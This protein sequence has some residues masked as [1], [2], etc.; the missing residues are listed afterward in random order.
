MNLV[1]A[2]VT[3]DASGRG[4]RI[5]ALLLV[6]PADRSRRLQPGTEVIFGIRP[7]KISDTPRAGAHRH[8]F[9]IV[10][11]ESLGAETIFAGRMPGIDKPLFTRVGPDIRVVARRAPPLHL[12]LSAAHI[13]DADGNALRP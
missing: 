11:V 10:Q 9:E 12:D 5:G 7:E 13:F 1:K 6:F 8:R 3:D 4:I 2:V